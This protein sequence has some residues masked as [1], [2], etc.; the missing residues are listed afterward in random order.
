[1]STLLDLPPPDAMTSPPPEA[2]TVH[3]S[4]GAWHI[5]APKQVGGAS[6]G[7]SHHAPPVWREGNGNA[8]A[9]GL[10]KEDDDASPSLPVSP[11]H[12][13]PTQ[14]Q[15]ENNEQHV[16]VMSE[17]GPASESESDV[18][19]QPDDTPSL[20]L[21]VYVLVVIVAAAIGI[22]AAVVMSRRGR[23]SSG[24]K[25]SA[26][27]RRTRSDYEASEDEDDQLMPK[28]Y[29]NKPT[30]S[31]IVL[32]EHD[33]FQGGTLLLLPSEPDDIDLHGGAEDLVGTPTN[34]VVDEIEYRITL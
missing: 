30:R 21:G 24:Y 27:D 22:A 15:S 3:K 17:A 18:D 2:S 16:A 31:A 20:P 23:R 25:S 34:R 11:S 12:G 13:Q 5:K 32:D 29:E 19:P 9:D 28:G 14:S 8:R 33:R 10:P 26:S 6:A 4:N 7:V 1:M